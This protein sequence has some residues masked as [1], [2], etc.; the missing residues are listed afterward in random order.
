MPRRDYITPVARLS[1]ISRFKPRPDLRLQVSSSADRSSPVWLDGQTLTGTRYVF[2]PDT[3]GITGVSFYL[4]GTLVQTEANAPW[5][6]QGTTAGNANPWDTTAVADGNHTIRADVTADGSVY[7]T[8]S[9]LNV[10]NLPPAAQNQWESFAV[11]NIG[12]SI[13]TAFIVDNF[14]SGNQYAAAD[15]MQVVASPTYAGSKAAQYYVNTGDWALSGDTNASNRAESWRSGFTGFFNGE[16]SSTWVGF[17]VFFPGP[18]TGGI[19]YSPYPNDD[20]NFVA[21]VHGGAGQ[22]CVQ[23]INRAEGFKLKVCG[24]SST[25]TSDPGFHRVV[26]FGSNSVTGYGSAGY[27]LA[28][29]TW[30]RFILGAKWSSTGTGEIELWHNGV[31]VL[32]RQTGQ[33]T[34]Y[35]GLANYWKQG[36][37]RKAYSTS[38]RV[39]HDDLRIGST[40]AQVA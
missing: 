2:V 19:Q 23:F 13:S 6:Y 5:D 18:V 7:Q 9:S 30:H 22:A 11:G 37:Y 39:F 21:Q 31:N 3:T 38:S 27:P 4:D 29:D 36:I 16:G 33:Y 40:K 10:T 32:P 12:A 25:N 28:A 15:R 34:M 14:L 8:Q 35:T 26:L 1:G 24:G 17:S 20:W